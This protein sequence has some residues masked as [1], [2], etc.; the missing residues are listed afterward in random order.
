M[1][2]TCLPL[3]GFGQSEIQVETNFDGRHCRGD[4]GAC[5]FTPAE[6]GRSANSSLAYDPKQGL[7]LKIKTNNLSNKQIIKAIGEPITETS[8]TKDLKLTVEADFDVESV[9]L[10]QLNMPN[11]RFT[12]RA[13]NYPIT[14][15][16]DMLLVVF[17]IE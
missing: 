7:I 14:F 12:I 11:E 1:L 2:I 17:K 3:L 6:Q 15:K 8:K 10:R 4:R 16:D 13:G 5:S 9:L